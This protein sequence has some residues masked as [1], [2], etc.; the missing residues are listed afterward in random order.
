MLNITRVEL[1][2]DGWTFN[3]LSPRVATITNP[4]GQRKVSYFGFDTLEKANVF[5]QW[6]L[7]NQKCSFATVRTS[8]RLSMAFECKAWAVPTELIVQLAE[9]D[10][11]Q[12]LNENK[13]LVSNVG[14]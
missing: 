4:L 11:N 12:Q 14:L 3:I 7:E 9:Q 13:S 5:K 8:E 2:S 10:N 6:L 1:N